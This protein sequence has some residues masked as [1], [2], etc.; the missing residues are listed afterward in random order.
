MEDVPAPP[1]ATSRRREALSAAGWSRFPARF[2][3]D[4]HLRRVQTIVGIC[5]GIASMA[6]GL[7]SLIRTPTPAN[8]GELLAIIQ[9]ADGRQAVPDAAIEVLSDENALVASL[10]P[11]SS[12]RVRQSLK[13]G[14]YV[15]RVSHPSYA[16]E[17]RKIEVQAKRIVR[18]TLSLREGSSV[19]LDRAKGALGAARSMWEKLG[20]KRNRPAE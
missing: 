10:S 3:R 2:F 15:V 16:A 17:S 9:D 18:L 8:E 4:K 7:Y 19:P 6:G 1:P 14:V 11:D 5:V 20:F 13:E 12:G